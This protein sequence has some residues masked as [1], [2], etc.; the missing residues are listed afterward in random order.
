[1]SSSSTDNETSEPFSPRTSSII[2]MAIAMAFHFGGYE[3][4]RNSCLAL[5]TSSDH[6]F[7]SPAAFPLANG[8][9]SPFSVGLLWLY[10]Q[11]LEAGGPRLA[12]R[13]ST[14]ASILVIALTAAGL[15]LNLPPILSQ[16]LVGAIFLFQNSYQYLLYTQQWSFLTSIMTPEEGARWFASLAGLSSV[17][18]SLAGSL[19]PVL[20]PRLGLLGLMA[21][22]CVTLTVTLICQ[23]RAYALSQQHGFL[24][25]PVHK[26]AKAASNRLTAAV[27][28]FRRVPTL[29]ALLLEVLSFQ[30]LNTILNVA[31]VRAL[32]IALPADLERSAYTGRLYSAISGVSA[33]LQ[34]LVLPVVLQH[35][36]PAWLWRLMPLVPLVV[37]G[38]QATQSNL[39]LSLLAA[40]FFFAKTMDYSLRSVIYP[41]VYQ[42]LDYESRYLG[43]EIIGVLGSRFGKSGMSLALSGLTT[44]LGSAFGTLQLIQLSV[45][46]TAAWTS[47]TWWLGRLLPKLEDAQAMVEE[48]QDQEKKQR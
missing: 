16:I 47:S 5:F 43:E 3:F 36:E 44:L 14:L 39:S 32:K 41:M 19:V 25:V 17:V 6:G 4:V 21:V 28:L 33:A 10:S 35:T 11:Q 40:A 20:L 9:V 27:D 31:F 1:M 18:C 15:S 12:L 22:T 23:D 37:C 46:A 38:Y 42:P 30:S 8:L 7:A 2:L 26:K 34:F 29:R 24:P 48:R 45:V 13:R